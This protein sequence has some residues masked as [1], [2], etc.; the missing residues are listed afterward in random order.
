[1]CLVGKTMW[2]ILVIFYLSIESQKSIHELWIKRRRVIWYFFY[3][4]FHNFQFLFQEIYVVWEITYS[5]VD[6]KFR[7]KR[8][9]SYFLS[10][11]LEKFLTK[12]KMKR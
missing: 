6:R 10:E 9:L 2:S 3:N 7:R 5:A 8:S 1:M 11:S 4:R 12:R